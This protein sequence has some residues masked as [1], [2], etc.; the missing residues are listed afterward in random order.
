MLEIEILIEKIKDNNWLFN[1]DICK[2][3][4]KVKNPSPHIISIA[5]TFLKF[6]SQKQTNWKSFTVFSH[7]IMNL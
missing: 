1:H 7:I 2:K 4:G 5:E 3:F 6:I